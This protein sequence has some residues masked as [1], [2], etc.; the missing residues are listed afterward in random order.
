MVMLFMLTAP[1]WISCLSAWV[2]YKIDCKNENT[3][4]ETRYYFS[5]EV[6]ESEL[7]INYDSD[8]EKMKEIEYSIELP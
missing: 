8:F 5:E 6:F 7:K 4:H 3:R 1:I 2:F